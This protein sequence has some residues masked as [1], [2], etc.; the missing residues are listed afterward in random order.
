MAKLEILNG[1]KN[2]ILFIN[3]DD[4]YLKTIEG[5]KLIKSGFSTNCDLKAYDIKSNLYSSEFKIKYNN[6]EYEISVPLPYHLISDVLISINVALYYGIDINKIINILKNYKT[7]DMRMDIIK[8]ENIIINDCYN[9]SFESLTGILE[10]LENENQK[11]L[12]IL[13]SIKELGNY[14]DEIHNKLKFYLNKIKNKEL[15]LIGKEIKILKLDA[16][17]FNNYNE[18]INYLKT[19]DIKNYIIL[20]KGS[21]K[22]KLENITNYFIKKTQ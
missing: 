3:G 6:K 4:K 5:V 14:S 1:M 9:S 22:L 7:Y 12:L 17:Y 16:L 18:C 20:I 10:V 21:R 19:K 8:N 11:K 13:G 15:I 2:K